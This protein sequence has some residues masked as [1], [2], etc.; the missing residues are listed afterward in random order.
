MNKQFVNN[1]FSANLPDFENRATALFHFQYEQNAVYR[2]FCDLLKIQPPAVTAASHIPFL[3]IC[4]FKTHEVKT[5]VFEPEF[6]FESS[7]TSQTTQSRHWVKDISVYEESFKR[8]F[9]QQYGRIDNWCILGLLPSYL[10]RGGSSLV[11]MVK[12]MMDES[13]HPNNGFYLHNNEELYKNL[14]LLET[15][16]QNT[17]LIGVTYALLDF[18]EKYQL[19][20]YN[21]AIMETGGMKGR[22]EELTGDEVHLR[23]KK[24][25]GVPTIHSEY[26]M[27]ELLSQ[28]Y[29]K[30]D[31][32]F[33]CP[34]WM[35]VI[36]RDEDDPLYVKAKGRGA[37][38]IIDLANMYSCSFIATDD[39]G[40]VYE[41]GSFKILGRMDNSDI[42][43][44]SLLAV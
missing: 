36:V 10:E 35:R 33:H 26:G 31:G 4:F 22:R 27:T 29:S 38:N 13:Q 43:G 20:C 30:G 7:G 3:P 19:Q 28:A 24:S 16:G 41:D 8:G 39:V 21:T 23:L 14:K 40:E 9:E 18:A 1:L 25:F 2:S 44:C 42:R 12:Q 11:Y 32:I 5:T 37:V 15:N 6:I 17:L 34:P